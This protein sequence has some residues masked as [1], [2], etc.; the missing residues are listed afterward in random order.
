MEPLAAWELCLS[1]NGI[2]HPLPVLHQP[3]SLL[4]PECPTKVS[5]SSHHRS[6]GTQ[7]QVAPSLSQPVN[8]STHGQSLRKTGDCGGLVTLVGAAG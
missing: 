8:Q 6:K 2:R 4:C 5:P 7:G 1:G 3:L